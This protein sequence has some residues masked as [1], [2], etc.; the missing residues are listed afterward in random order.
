RPG[1]LGLR[2]LTGSRM[3]VLQLPRRDSARFE[4]SKHRLLPPTPKREPRQRPT[5]GVA[6]P[7]P[8]RMALQK[9]GA[10]LLSPGLALRQQ[11]SPAQA[12]RRRESQYR[13]RAL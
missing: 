13:R 7:Q 8:K 6:N 10:G 5:N 2:R 12:R 9:Q 11:Y 4:L 3:A 1:I